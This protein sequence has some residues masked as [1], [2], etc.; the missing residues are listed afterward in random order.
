YA[1]SRRV[2]WTGFAC[3]GLM[4]VTLYVV[5]VLPPRNEAFTAILGQAPRIALGSLVAYWAGEF[6]NAFV[7]AKLKVRTQGRWLWSRT[8]SSTLVGQLV[9]TAVFLFI[10]FYGVWPNDLLWTVFVS[11]YVFK[12]GV[13]VLFTPVTYQAVNFLKQA[14]REDY[15]DRNTDFNPLALS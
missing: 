2:I 7:L 8:I 10:A 4:V 1:R 13:E 9:D 15:F 5:D 14:E 11:N 12:V 3:L 6:T